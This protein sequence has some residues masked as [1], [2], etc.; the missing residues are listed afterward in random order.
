MGSRAGFGRMQKILPIRDPA[1]VLVVASV[2]PATKEL[3][4]L[5]SVAFRVFYNFLYI[6]IHSYPFG[7]GIIFF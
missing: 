2:F 3:F 1:N 5:L 7:T 4:F 6:H